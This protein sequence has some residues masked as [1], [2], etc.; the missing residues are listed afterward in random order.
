MPYFWFTMVTP[1][2]SICSVGYPKA[3]EMIL[4]LSELV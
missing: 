3:L 2:P 4:P 1:D